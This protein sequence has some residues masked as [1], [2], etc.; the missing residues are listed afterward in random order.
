VLSSGCPSSS[1]VHSLQA[2]KRKAQRSGL[3]DEEQGGEGQDFDEERAALEAAEFE[4]AKERLT[5]KHK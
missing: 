3:V 5:L 2:A 1:R 4:R